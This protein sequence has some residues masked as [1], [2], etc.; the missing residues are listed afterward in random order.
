MT[1]DDADAIIERIQAA[2]PAGWNRARRQ[3]WHDALLSA[4]GLTVGG[5]VRAYTALRGDSEYCPSIAGF[6]ARARTHSP[7]PEQRIGCPECDNSGWLF[8]AQDEAIPCR[9]RSA[10]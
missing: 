1:F 7:A 10:A 5:A 6:L 8:N 4:S 9:C 3:E 2:W